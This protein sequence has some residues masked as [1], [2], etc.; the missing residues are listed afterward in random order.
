[1][2]ELTIVTPCYRQDNLQ[3]LFESINFDITKRWIIVYDPTKPTI[4]KPI[5]NHPQISEFHIEYTE[6]WSWCGNSQRDYAIEKIESGWIYFLDDDN[7]MHPGFWDIF[8]SVTLPFYYTFDMQNVN[9]ESVQLPGGIIKR[10]CI[11]T[12]MF[13]VNKEHIKTVKWSSVG[14]KRLGDYTFINNIREANNL[15]K[16]HVYIPKKACYHNYIPKKVS[17][18]PVKEIIPE[19]VVIPEPSLVPPQE[20]K[21]VP[22]EALPEPQIEAPASE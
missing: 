18:P 14:D 15:S 6:P 4:L 22:S 7:V 21:A 9:S 12:A 13:L 20:D 17:V 10:C 16:L 19:S 11:D 2:E 8:S 3:K 5:F 1:M